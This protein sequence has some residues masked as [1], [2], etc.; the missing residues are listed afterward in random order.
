MNT[1]ITINFDTPKYSQLKSYYKPKP[2][3][4]KNTIIKKDISKP[5]DI[6]KLEKYV[7]NYG[8]AM[9]SKHEISIYKKLKGI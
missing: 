4:Y 5:I 3:K 6:P 1:S 9:L 8:I 2:A 7:M